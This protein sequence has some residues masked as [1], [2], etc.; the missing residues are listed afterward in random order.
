MILTHSENIKTCE[1][2]S[3]I[4]VQTAKV[5]QSSEAIKA[6]SWMV[7]Q[8]LIR[9]AETCTVVCNQKLIEEECKNQSGSGRMNFLY[10]SDTGFTSFLH[11][12]FMIRSSTITLF[13]SNDT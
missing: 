8:K 10:D 5:L 3:S 4:H 9:L 2:C 1:V 12:Q 11:N 6:L 7:F 13:V